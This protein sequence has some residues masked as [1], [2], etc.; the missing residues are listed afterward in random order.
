MYNIKYAYFLPYQHDFFFKSKIAYIYFISF[1]DLSKLPK[2][3]FLQPFWSQQ[4]F[5]VFSFL[6]TRVIHKLQFGQNYFDSTLLY[7]IPRAVAIYARK[8]FVFVGSNKNQVIFFAWH[9]TIK[10]SCKILL[11]A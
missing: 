3:T 5:N 7:L 10:M 1:I 6:P 4:L 9:T 8:I 11:K 2:A